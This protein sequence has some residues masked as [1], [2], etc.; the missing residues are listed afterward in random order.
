M[1]L[2]AAYAAFIAWTYG[3]SQNVAPVLLFDEYFY[4]RESLYNPDG[5]P[6]ANFG[7]THLLQLV[8][9]EANGLYYSYKALIVL[10]LPILGLGIFLIV[11][12][13]VDS[14][15]GGWISLATLSFSYSAW[16]HMLIPEIPFTG[17]VLLAIAFLLRAIRDSA[18]S[19]VDLLLSA[20]FLGISSLFKVHSMFILPAIFVI[21]LVM[22]DGH[23]YQTWVRI[24]LGAMYSLVAILVK[25][26]IGFALAGSYGLNF[27]GS[28]QVYLDRF[29]ASV[30]SNVSDT[31]EGFVNTKAA[32]LPQGGLLMGIDSPLDTVAT[33]ELIDL[34]VMLFDRTAALLFILVIAFAWLF[35][36]RLL[37]YPETESQH[38]LARAENA[39]L[40]IVLNLFVI[41]VSFNL[42]ATFVGDD[43]SE[44]VLLRYMEYGILP[45]I[46]LSSIRLMTFNR[47]DEKSIWSRSRFYF[48][49]GIL[50]IAMFGNQSSITA[51]YADSSFVPAMGEVWVWLPFIAITVS[52]VWFFA[53]NTR[54]KF[55]PIALVGVLGLHSF[56]GFLTNL[57]FIQRDELLE[58]SKRV[59][60]SIANEG[61]SEDLFQIVRVPQD[62]GRIGTLLGL[63]SL[64]YGVAFGTHRVNLS[65]VPEDKSQVVAI[66][67]VYFDLE[68]TGFEL[69]QTSVD[70]EV[71][72]RTVH[73]DEKLIESVKN[74]SLALLGDFAYYSRN[75]LYVDGDSARLR[76]TQGYSPGDVVELCYTLPGEI[77]NRNARLTFNA[78]E[79][80]T[81]INSIDGR[82]PDCIGFEITNKTNEITI[83]V[84]ASTMT[85]YSELGEK[86]S[87]VGPGIA[88]LEVFRDGK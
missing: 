35:F 44:R 42:F 13:H 20:A 58:R 15:V 12:D 26:G 31:P 24:G 74:R 67:Q 33:F 76:L 14:V 69:I 62:A 27:L 11:R 7:F 60:A 75:A 29:L 19:Y 30:F 52:I 34:I 51:S 50:L 84:E 65:Q 38:R 53:G 45:L 70:M 88:S 2:F 25:S 68:D 40:L 9:G 57:D 21:L 61:S 6:T 4:F 1:G 87:T 39:I 43:H 66:G 18:I 79:Y 10:F 72:E 83:V 23:R 16:A 5:I 3:I 59:A 49:G 78:V 80:S 81:K 36:V 22:L 77:Q 32:T 85:N 64:S 73:G 63:E 17:F 41:A 56:V 46:A 37:T 8:S 82:S 48:L 28:Y 86:L 55:R 54:S 47:R 71:L